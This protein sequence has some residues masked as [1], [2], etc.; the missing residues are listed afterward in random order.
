MHEEPPQVRETSLISVV[1]TVYHA[2]AR[3]AKIAASTANDTAREGAARGGG[4]I[5]RPANAPGR[6]GRDVGAHEHVSPCGRAAGCASHASSRHSHCNAHRVIRCCLVANSLALPSS[7]AGALEGCSSFGIAVRPGLQL[8]RDHDPG[9]G[10]EDCAGRHSLTD[11]GSGAW[12]RRGLAR[13]RPVPRDR[14]GSA[15]QP[16]SA[17]CKCQRILTRDLSHLSLHASTNEGCSYRC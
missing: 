13:P 11:Q 14:A 3:R 5:W 6:L 7:L 8:L 12:I 15:R 17:S 4:A 1:V 10:K 2:P 16:V 9:I